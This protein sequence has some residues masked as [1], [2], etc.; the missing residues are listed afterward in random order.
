MKDYR[1]YLIDLDGTMYRGNQVIKEAP[2][3]IRWLKE[4]E[5]PFLF[6][7]NNSSMTPEQISK[8]LNKMGIEAEPTHVYTTSMASAELIPTDENKTRVYAIGEEGLLT[9]LVHKGCVLTDEDP[10]YVVLGIDRNFS[11]EKMMKAS[12]AIQKGAKFLSTNSDRAIPTEKG[13]VPGNGALTAA[14]SIASGQIPQFIGKPEAIFVELA[15]KKLGCFPQDVLLVGDNL[16]TDIAAGVNAQVDTLLVYTGITRPEDLIRGEI[17]PTYT[18][19]H[20]K[21]WMKRG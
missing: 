3:F 16:H 11:Y 18:V 10:S 9:A 7:T 4:K 14:I 13:L 21:E 1:A 17:Q 5:I 6:L 15:L 20:L 8:K 19:S 2:E 12:L